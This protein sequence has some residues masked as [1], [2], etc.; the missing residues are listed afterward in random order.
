MASW[1]ER[2]KRIFLQRPVQIKISSE[3]YAE[4]LSVMNKLEKKWGRDITIDEVILFLC[5]T[6]ER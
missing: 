2:D 4:L 1:V 3:T 5:Q 6:L